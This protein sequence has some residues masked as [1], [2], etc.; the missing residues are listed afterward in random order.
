MNEM[1]D[2]QK[3]FY[4]ILPTECKNEFEKL[5]AEYKQLEEHCGNFSKN[6]KEKCEAEVKTLRDKII[7]NF[8]NGIDGK[9]DENMLFC[10][11]LLQNK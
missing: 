1:Q 9:I 6:V 10:F 8:E 2:Y 4:E 5:L 11:M 7:N 3:E